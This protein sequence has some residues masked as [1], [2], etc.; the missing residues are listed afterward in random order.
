MTTSAP[1]PD[2]LA[3]FKEQLDL[4]GKLVGGVRTLS[5]VGRDGA[6]EEAP[7]EVVH[8]EGKMRLLHYLPTVERPASP[9]VL[10]VYAIFNRYYMI[11][12]QPERSL[13][14]RLL[15]E[16][17]D[18][19]VIDWGYPDRSDRWL[20]LDDYVSGYVTD[21]VEV[22]REQH[23]VDQVNVVGICQGGAAAVCYAALHPERVK[24]LVTMVS[25]IDFHVDG[26][27]L[28]AWTRAIDVDALVDAFG[29]VPGELIGL[30]FMAR[31]PF[32]RQLRKYLDVVDIVDDEDRL[33][34]FLQ[35]ERWIWDTPDVPGEAFRQWV[36]DF[37][38]GNK[39]VKGEVDLGRLTMPI[40]NVY[41]END[42]LVPPE[43][44][45]ALE[46]YVGT[47][48]YTGRA[49]PVGHIGMYVSSRMQRE[50]PPAVAGWLLAR[51]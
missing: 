35:M 16:G 5:D 6:P 27:V 28:N 21:C 47:D 25:P 39:L 22:L 18:L 24:N 46:R 8:A 20:T 23:G 17:L 11:D 14:R 36:K 50:V 30:G 49:F 44:A 38:Q 33:R 15:D 40:L 26:T 29:T 9:P 41:A 32:E 19:Y 4:A 43:S 34:S 37:Y 3:V 45:A 12:L 51:S 48:D 13:V 10:I 2:P 7:S 42:D 31:S 1:W